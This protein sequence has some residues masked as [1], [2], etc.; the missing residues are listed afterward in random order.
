MAVLD[1]GQFTPLPR[2]GFLVGG[3]VRDTL[4]GRAVRDLDWLVPDPEEAAAAAAAALG[5]RA[6]ALDATRGHWRVAAGGVTR[7]Y[8]P[9]GTDLEANLRARDFCAN[10]L[11]AD[12]S[13]ALVDPT[14]G[15]GDL[16][17]KRLRMV[18]AANL[19]ADPLRGLRGARLAAE[20]GFDLEA[21]T[22][23][24]IGEHSGAVARGEVPPPA[25]ERVGV[26]LSRLLLSERAGPGAAL[27]HRLGL[28]RA[29]LPEL[30]RA[31]GVAQGGFHHLD[32]LAHSLEA[33]NQ[34]TQG[35][36]E[37]DLALRWATLLHDVGKPDTK[38][39]GPS[40]RFHFYG[41][42]TLGA[43]MTKDVL[44]RLRLPSATVERASALVRRHMLPIPKTA[45]E[46]RRFVHRRRALLPDLLKLMIADREAA[47]GPLASEAN[48][49]SYRIA[50]SKVLEILAEPPPKA[51]LLDGRA[52]MRLLELPPGPRVG[53]AVRF[54]REA[55]AVGDVSTP[56]EAAA[57][58]KRYAAARGWGA[59][60]G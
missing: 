36:P 27:L 13:G 59:G 53:E 33:L 35:F 21:E 46:A 12:L 51:P 25:A 10:A 4:L 57:A 56:E 26:E 49:R 15:R 5:T 6:F 3:A 41:H 19:W 50:L 23:A 7:D 43:E 29:Y 42:D 47:R 60:A 39:Y 11:A 22:A 44:K 54:V 38:R 8:A 14:G 34:L 58:L 2:A 31:A 45:R 32:V 18:D 9:L 28:L 52:V 1:M 48:R 20:L 30:E 24:A 37:A 16:R 40:G 55:E 17:A